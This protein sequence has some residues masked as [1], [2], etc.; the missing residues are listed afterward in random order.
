MITYNNLINRLQI[1]ADHHLFIKRFGSGQITDIDASISNSPLY[2]MMW[3]IP[4]NA[5]I[6]ENTLAYTIRLM[7]FDIANI[8][9]A[10]G[11]DDSG[12]REREML[13]DG[14][15]TLADIVKT[16][17]YGDATVDALDLASEPADWNIEYPVQCIPFTQRFVD[18]VTGWYADIKITVDFDNSDCDNPF[19]N[20]G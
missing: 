4:Q 3:A 2:P 20:N 13:S 15:R 16:F 19:L 8:D 18:Y 9:S 11:I 12:I 1:I 5:E 14:L 17:R 6:A 10:T 7:V